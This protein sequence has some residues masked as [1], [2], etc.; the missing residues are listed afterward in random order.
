M[1]KLRYADYVQI[2]ADGDV[3]LFWSIPYTWSPKIPAQ[4]N[5]PKEGGVELEGN[6]ILV[7]ASYYP[8]EGEPLHVEDIGEGSIADILL[9]GKYGYPDDDE[10]YQA[11]N[12][13]HTQ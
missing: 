8:C 1:S 12:E 4:G 11:A 5:A 6:P 13:E 9:V 3:E 7:G 2:Q 10:C